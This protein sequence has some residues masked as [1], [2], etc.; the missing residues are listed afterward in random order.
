[1]SSIKSIITT[2]NTMSQMGR[3]EEEGG[4]LVVDVTKK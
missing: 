4:G 3:D 2:I 1:M